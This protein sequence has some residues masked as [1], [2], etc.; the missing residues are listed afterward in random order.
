METNDY[1]SHQQTEHIVPIFTTSTPINGDKKHQLPATLYLGDFGCASKLPD[2]IACNIKA[3]L[4]CAYEL[5]NLYVDAFQYKKL[6]WDDMDDFDIGQDLDSAANFI[7]T[8]LSKGDSVL[9]HC[10]AGRSRS[11]SACMAYLIKYQCCSFD[12][13]FKLVQRS[14]PSA[15]PNDGFCHQLRTFA[16]DFS[17]H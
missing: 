15:R 1:M 11:V 13:A 17:I 5:R 16:S 14:R 9:V 3:I 12:N 6:Y 2:L 10:A 4:N 7:H 8:S